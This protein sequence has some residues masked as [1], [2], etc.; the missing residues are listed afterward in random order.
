MAVNLDD[1]GVGDG[2][3]HVRVTRYG[4][5]NLLEN[6][7]FDPIAITRENCIPMAKLSREIPLGAA[8]PGNPEHCF[9]KYPIVA[10]RAAGV[11]RLA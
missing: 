7:G 4:V 3:F 6:T 8:R 2:V 1:G 9:Q 10:A 5:E 11:R